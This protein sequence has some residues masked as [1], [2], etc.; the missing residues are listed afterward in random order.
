V[1]KEL[2]ELGII[3]GT[4]LN[5]ALTRKG[6]AEEQRQMGKV[7]EH[8]E[9]IGTLGD[10]VLRAALVDILLRCDVNTKGEISIIKQGLE[11]NDTLYLIGV[12]LGICSSNLTL[13]RNER[14]LFENSEAEHEIMGNGTQ[15]YQRSQAEVTIISDTVEALIGAIYIDLGFQTALRFIEKWFTPYLE[16]KGLVMNKR[17]I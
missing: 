13:S 5:R 16:E 14:L 4:L 11:N 17:T 3:D 2:D 12:K 1:T 9:S 15:L 6:Y 8:Q 10:G 7:C